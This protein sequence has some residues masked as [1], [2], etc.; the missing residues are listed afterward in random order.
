M[1]KYVIVSGTTPSELEDKVAHNL[2]FM[3]VLCGGVAFA[4]GVFYQAMWHPEV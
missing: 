1:K 2:H 3:Y 4:N